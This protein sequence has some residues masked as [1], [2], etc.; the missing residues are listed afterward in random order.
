LMYPWRQRVLRRPLRQ[1]KGMQYPSRC[2]LYFITD[3][4]SD[5]RDACHDAAS[6]QEGSCVF[7]LWNVPVISSSMCIKCPEKS[8]WCVICIYRS[9]LSCIMRVNKLTGGVR[10]TVRR[11]RNSPFQS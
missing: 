2:N 1:E 9:Q 6:A 7:P 11:Q 3:P 5:D 8:C 4:C 10:Y